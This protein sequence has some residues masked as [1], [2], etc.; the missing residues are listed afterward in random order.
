MVLHWKEQELPFADFAVFESWDT[1]GASRVDLLNEGEV[2]RLRGTLTTANL[3]DLLGVRPALGRTF[4]EAETQVA[5]LSDSLWRRRFGADPGVIGKSITLATGR[6]RERRTIEII[7]VLPAGFTFTYPEETEMWLPLT[8]AAISREFQAAALYGAVG[9]LHMGSSLDAT[10]AAMQVLH[11]PEDRTSRGRARIWLEPIHEYAVGNSRSA[12]LFVSALT[13]LVLLSGATNAAT[14]FTA[15]TLSRLPELRVRRALGASQGR[16]VRQ[17]LVEV[18][19]LA[20]LAGLVG[21]ATVALLFPMLK[22]MLPAGLP[23]LDEVSLDSLTFVSVLVAVVVSTLVSGSIPAWLGTRDRH[24]LGF[25]ETRTATLGARRL[26][27]RAGLL[28]MQFALVSTLLITGSMLV[29]SF[30]KIVQVDKGFEANSNVYVAEIQLMHQAYR[31]QP[32]RERELLIRAREMKHIDAATL[33]SA[34]PLGGADYVRVLLTTQGQSVPANVRMVDPAYF[35]VLRIRLLSGRG[36]NQD[37]QESVAVVSEALAQTL[38]PGENPIGRYLWGSGGRIVGVVA[39]VRTRF[40]WERP[41]PAYYVPLSQERSFRLFLLVRSGTGTQQV[42]ADLR[43]IVG[44]VYP[45]QPIQRLTTLAHVLDHSVSDRRAYAV[46]SSALAVVMLLLSGLGLCGHLSHV[47]GE[48]AREL[49]IRS[50]LGA[51]P[52]QQL[53]QLLRHVVPALIAGLMVAMLTTYL[54]YP[55]VAPFLFEIERFDVLSCAMGAVLVAAF[56]AAAILMPVRRIT[57]LTEGTLLRTT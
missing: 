37:E 46:I 32:W 24:D 19:M 53:H 16:L 47:V 40:L 52:R 21:C 13:V 5:V 29:R 10:E 25:E 41:T 9:R 45:E 12:L 49:A 50:A 2:Y 14:V 7:G 15:S 33:T 20:I 11:D 39:D 35:D 4:Q 38:Y 44:K 30:W 6:N 54:L 23:R 26:R 3:F 28:V 1:G 34:I 56:A 36:F 27:L 51:S 8:W 31:D 22:A 42:A 43:H 18:G 55:F 57:R 17:V 48:R